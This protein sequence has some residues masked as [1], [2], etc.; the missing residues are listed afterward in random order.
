MRFHVCALPHTQITP[1]FATCAYTEKVRKF[2]RMMMARG[3]TVFLYAGEQNT[4]PC[5]EHIPC[6]TEAERVLACGRQHFT[7]ASFD[8]NAPHWQ[9]FNAKTVLGIRARAEPKDIICLIGGVAQQPVANAFPHIMA[10]EYGIGYGGSFAKYRVFESYAWM[11]HCYG[12]ELAKR[13]RGAHDADGRFFDAVIPGYFEPDLFPVVT[14]KSHYLLYVGRMIDR[15]G[16]HIAVQVA[17]AT[18][19]PLMMAG[20]GMPPKHKLVDYIGEVGPQD[21]ATLMGNAHALLAPTLYL[22]PFGNVVVE[23]QACGTPTITTDWGAFTETNV[24]GWTGFRCHTLREFVGAVD[25][26]QALDPHAIAAHARNRYSLDVIGEQYER[27]FD[28]LQLLWRK[29]WP[30]LD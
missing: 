14:Q 23:A 3:H 9:L 18:N 1:D 11:H 5:T 30:E 19:R 28:R 25:A 27:Y 16:I 6:I 29:G 13:G 17:E 2:C 12:Y 20:P 4:A 10:V 15:K 24:Q 8:S 22:E 7:A 26:V 21:R